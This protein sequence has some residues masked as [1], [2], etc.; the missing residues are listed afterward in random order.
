[1]GHPSGSVELPHQRAIAFAESV[2]HDP[3]GRVAQVFAK[4]VEVVSEWE[5]TP[6]QTKKVMSLV[7]SYHRGDKTPSSDCWTDEYRTE[8]TLQWLPWLTGLFGVNSTC[9]ST[10][11][12]EVEGRC[13]GIR[14]GRVVI[15]DADGVQHSFLASVVEGKVTPPHGVS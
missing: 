8:Q 3:D 4:T 2:G 1:M 14:G 5:L 11:E 10:D 7:L 6:Y 12:T 15:E 9:R 13:V